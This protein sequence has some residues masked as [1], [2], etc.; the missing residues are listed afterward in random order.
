MIHKKSKE[1]KAGEVPSHVIFAM[2]IAV[3]KLIALVLRYNSGHIARALLPPL[4]LS[5]PVQ[6]AK[7]Y[8]FIW[9]VITFA[10]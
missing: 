7:I 1:C 3:L 2:T 4:C 9:P 5:A 8:N 10:R 6:V